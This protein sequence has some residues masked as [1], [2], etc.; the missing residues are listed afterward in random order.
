MNRKF[1]WA[2][3]GL[4]GV[5][6]GAC[7][8][9]GNKTGTSRAD[10]IAPA[11]GETADESP[12]GVA[13]AEPAPSEAPVLASNA[14]TPR[15][16]EP[17]ARSSVEDFRPA[18]WVDQPETAGGVVRVGAVGEGRDIL[19]ARR[20]AV[21]AASLALRGQIGHDPAGV[22]TDRYTVVQLGNGNYRA[23]ILMSGRQ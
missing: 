15:V 22:E 23:F 4:I 2:V 7:G 14:D 20:E 19:D 18:W 17:R 3:V 13:R 11:P 6:L 1:S 21:R 5:G 12:A 16:G 10:P 9:G 8:G